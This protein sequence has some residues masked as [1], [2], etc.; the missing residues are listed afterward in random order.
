MAMM[1]IAEFARLSPPRLSLC[2]YVIPEDTGTGGDAAEHGEERFRPVPFGVVPDR[3]HQLSRRLG[4]DALEPQ[5]PDL[6]LQVGLHLLQ[7]L[8]VVRQFIVALAYGGTFLFGS[9]FIM[10]QDLPRQA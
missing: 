9:P 3:D 8:D 4:A 7:L 6:R 1:W 5:L 2:R 10:P